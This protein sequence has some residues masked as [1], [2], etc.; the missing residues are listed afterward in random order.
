M[1]NRIR[2]FPSILFVVWISL[3]VPL[4][5]EF[6][7]IANS[8][9][10]NISAYIVDT[11]T[12]ELVTIPGSPFGG[13]GSPWSVAIDPS[14]KF[15]YATGYYENTGINGYAIDPGTG[16]LSPLPGSPFPTFS[17][18]NI[19]IA[20][21]PSGKFAYVTSTGSLV[22]IYTVDSMT[23]ALTFEQLSGVEPLSRRYVAIH[24]SGK[25][26]Y[27]TEENAP[28][29]SGYAVDPNTGA[30]TPV[31]GS[32]FGV[33]GLEGEALA[34]DPSGNFLYVST[35][36][37]ISEFRVDLSTGALTSIPGP[38]IIDSVQQLAVS[39]AGSFLYAARS[40]VGISG[41]TI[42]PTS[43]SLSL[44]PGSPWGAIAVP[45]TYTA[46]VTVD[47]NGKFVY[48]ANSTGSLLAYAIDS[49]TGALTAIPGSPAPA[50]N[51]PLSMAVACP[52]TVL[53]PTTRATLTGPAGNNGW[54]LGMVTVTLAATAGGTPVSATYFSVDGGQYQA[55]AAPFPVSG[56]G[57]HP[58]LF[59]SVDTAGH[60]E[61]SHG[62]TIKIDSTPPVSHVAA[63]PATET[64]LNFNVQW[65]GTDAGS[66]VSD[67][68]IFVSDNGSPFTTWLT[69]TTVNQATFAGVSGHNYGFYSLAQDW[70]GNQESSKTVAEATT[71]VV[72]AIVK[73]VSHVAPLPATATSPNFS[74]Q[75]SGTDTGGPGISNYTIYVSDNAGPFTPW[76]NQTTATQ[77]WFVGQ[78]THS[79]GFYSIARDN[80]GNVETKSV[81]DATTYVPQME[82]DVNGDGF[83][84]CVD[85]DLVKA[86]FG[87]K[88]GQPGFNPA[89]DVNKDG[90]VNVLDLAIV[91]QKLIP[92]TKCP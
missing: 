90:V 9:S 25:F 80:A 52:G 47:C 48:A 84:N 59:Y 44:I 5:G 32:P 33:G 88:T 41:Y 42:D 36:G 4:S 37:Q 51:T 39:P 7:Y 50:G 75:W 12:G 92:G 21:P 64:S 66:G 72:V 1:N 86:S 69:Q 53:P 87:A 56:D 20:I 6:L 27:L 16:A 26:V 77:A 78:L 60:Q 73:P 68:T 24:P 31:P 38:S 11:S 8:G 79:Y 54:Y 55:Y 91:S 63:L 43:G 10:A 23:G 71:Q 85:V 14:G 65:S 76:L 34:I 57:T 74:L 82:G 67:F 46:T 49:Q 58:L 28:T 45:D 18:G 30:L 40:G 22:S 2:A 70:A 15:A 19:I 83:I 81:A 17:L 13:T 3:T 62:Q 89:A 35:G 61:T 29:V